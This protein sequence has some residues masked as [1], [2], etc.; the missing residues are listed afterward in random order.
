MRR[1]NGLSKRD[2]A[3]IMDLDPSSLTKIQKG[4]KALQPIYVARLKDRFGVTMDWVYLGDLSGVRKSL[5]DAL[6]AELR[7]D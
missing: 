2:L 4:E 7:R 5:A 6:E 3:G 1:V